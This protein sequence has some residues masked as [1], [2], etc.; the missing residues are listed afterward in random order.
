VPAIGSPPDEDSVIRHAKV[1]DEVNRIEDL[2]SNKTP[3]VPDMQKQARILHPEK[4]TKSIEFNSAFV[5]GGSVV[6]VG[7]AINLK[8]KDDTNVSGTYDVPTSA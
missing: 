6:T 5:D 7:S 4:C 3:T 8:I 2:Y 1:I